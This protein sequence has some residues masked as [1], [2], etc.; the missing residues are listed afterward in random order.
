MTA[1][2]VYAV[3]VSVAAVFGLIAGRVLA[4]EARF[5][6]DGFSYSNAGFAL[7]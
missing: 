7:A 5:S 4:V 6:P 2:F 1:Q 3:V